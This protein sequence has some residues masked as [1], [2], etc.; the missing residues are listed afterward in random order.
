MFITRLSVLATFFL[1]LLISNVNAQ[2]CSDATVADNGA[3]A[4]IRD[5]GGFQASYSFPCV[6]QGV[7]TEIA[8]PF[9]VFNTVPRGNSDDNVSK[10]RIDQIGNLPDG[11]C[12][13]TSKADNVF[14]RGEGGLLILRGIASDNAGQF[15]LNITV[16]FDTDG[17][18]LFDR[19]DVNY[20]KVSNTGRMIV[21][22][23]NPGTDC[24]DIDYDIQSN[25]A[26]SGNNTASRQ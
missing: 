7:Y 10:M 15:S 23:I 9:K 5:G 25:I 20:N 12:W 21:R 8:V 1:S 19:T 14:S 18:G 4:K 2:H 16:S 11:M 17:D 24:M 6:T 3:S 13:V 26:A 22:L